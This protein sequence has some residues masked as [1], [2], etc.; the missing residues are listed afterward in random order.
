MRNDGGDCLDVHDGIDASEVIGSVYRRA[1]QAFVCPSACPLISYRLVV[2][3]EIREADL[4]AITSLQKV[5]KLVQ[6]RFEYFKRFIDNI[7][8]ISCGL[9]LTSSDEE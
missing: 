6:G 2:D 8:Y 4:S 1:G 5:Q 9:E 7:E 3:G